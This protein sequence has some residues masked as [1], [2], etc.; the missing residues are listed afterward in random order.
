LNHPAGEIRHL[1]ITILEHKM[2]QT[3]DSLS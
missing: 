2:R 1:A 3:G